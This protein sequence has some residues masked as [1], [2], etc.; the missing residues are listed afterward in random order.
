[1]KC[2]YCFAE[3]DQDAAVC[4]VCGKDLTQTEEVT[5]EI[6]EEITN[7]IAEE[8]TNETAEETAAE[9]T[10]IE[11]E[12]AV[13]EAFP[14]MVKKKSKAWQVVLAVAGVLVLAVLL[15]GVI[16]YSMGLGD[17]VTGKLNAAFHELK[18]WR[19]NDIFYRL[20]YTQDIATVG[21]NEDTVVATVGDQ[22]L[23]NGELQV[24]YWTCV[25]DAV[26]YNMFADLDMSIPLDQQIY[27][28][29]TGK[30]YQQMFLE[31]ALESWHRY[32]VLIQM[33]QDNGFTLS[34]ED[35]A[36][37][38]SFPTKVEEMAKEYGYDDVE[39]FIDEQFFSGCSVEAY[40]AYNRTLFLSL[41]YYDSLYDSLMPTKEQVEAYYTD[42]E[43]EFIENGIDKDA[44]YYYD[45]RH[46]LIAEKGAAYGGTYTEQ[47]WE[48]WRASAQFVLDDFLADDPTEEK[49][50]ALAKELSVDTGSK[51][52]GG[53]YTNLTK[54]TNFVE[55]FKTWY[56]DESRKPGD[57][58]LVKTEHGYHIMYFSGKT[59]I[60]EYEAKTL[61]LSES[62]TKLLE[63][64]EAQRPIAVD[65]KQIKLRKIE[66]IAS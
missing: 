8:V 22:K 63:E 37:L 5:N 27:D 38:D 30:T 39:K 42:H 28:K 13:T 58:G 10:E 32:A 47:D 21:K 44:G 56:L 26:S 41:T 61:A 53:L 65:Y 6:A 60:W 3:L 1:M 14:A 31:N 23:T 50:A 66:L 9:V 54:D 12:P 57:T 2:K 40:L 46:I 49:F 29:E 16:V 24:H 11:V 33:S 43:G 35:Q 20:S 18:F 7:E 25:Y 55:E 45:V 15:T 59:P 34:E 48:D 4:P 19:E 51:E 64:A 52:N 36:F 62:T 17:A